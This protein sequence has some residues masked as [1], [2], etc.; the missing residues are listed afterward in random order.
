MTTVG[1][2]K[3]ANGNGNAESNIITLPDGV[4]VR[5]IP[6]SA[7]LLERVNREI[8]TP[9]PPTYHDETTDQD[10]PNPMHPDYIRAVTE[11]NAARNEAAMDALVMFGIELVD[12]MPSDDAW[13]E[14][15]Q[16]LE[17]RGHSIGLDEFD[18]DD[19]MDLEYLYKRM[20]LAN[21][22]VLEAVTRASGLTTEEVKAAEDSFRGK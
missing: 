8:A 19:P 14:K 9:I 4:K 6:V 5:I 2:L 11:A 1:I 3:N 20:I 21:G 18:L 10:R 16:Y 7:A 13:L 17:K 12:G 22:N 15:L